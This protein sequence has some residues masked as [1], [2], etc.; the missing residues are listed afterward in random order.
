M[1]NINYCVRC[2]IENEEKREGKILWAGPILVEDQLVLA[3]S[4]GRAVFVAARDGKTLKSLDLSDKT[5]LS[6]VAAQKT[7]VFLTNRANLLAYR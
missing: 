2:H 6:P 3:G 5:L 4:N 7:L 1:S